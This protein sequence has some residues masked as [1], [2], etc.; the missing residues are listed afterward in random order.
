MAIFYEEDMVNAMRNQNNIR[1]ISIFGDQSSGKS[2]ILDQLLL[3]CGIKYEKRPQGR[4]CYTDATEDELECDDTRKNYQP[5]RY[6]YYK[7][8]PEVD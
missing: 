7:Y 4:T 1:I 8:E 3:K 2:V 6:L 5:V